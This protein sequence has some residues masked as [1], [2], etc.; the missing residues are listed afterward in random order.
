MLATV[1][2][3]PAEGSV[4][5]AFTGV[6]RFLHITPR[7]FLPMRSVP[8]ITLV[9]GKGIEGDRY[10][11]GREEGFYSDRPEDGRQIT[12]FEIETLVALKRDA[13]IALGPHEHRRNV[14]VEG[15]PLN[16]L[17]GRRFRL[18]ATLLEATRL[19]VPCRHIEEITGKA[20]FDPLINRSGLNCRIL[21][22]GIVRV[23][24][25]VRNA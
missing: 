22:G 3:A 23:G 9:P 20:I 1:L 5:T 14:T 24:D 11:I 21:E 4:A 18:G 13:G 15:V 10:M 2:D 7:A 12:L 17:V 25:L 8:E 19:S 16:H 6:V